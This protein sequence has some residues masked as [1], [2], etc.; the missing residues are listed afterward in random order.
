MLHLSFVAQEEF[1]ST[2]VAFP[3]IFG[4][5]GDGEVR[6]RFFWKESWCHSILRSQCLVWSQVW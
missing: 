4:P 6:D 3:D 1:S 5:G 2:F